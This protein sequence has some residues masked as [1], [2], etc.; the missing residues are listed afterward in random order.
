MAEEQLF[1]PNYEHA[2][3]AFVTINENANLNQPPQIVRQFNGKSFEFAVPS[4]CGQFDLIIVI[5]CK[6]WNGKGK[7]SYE[8]VNGPLS[9][10]IHFIYDNV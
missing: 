6:F 9:K 8:L 5:L 2:A 10:F 7:K 3:F 1:F 4:Q